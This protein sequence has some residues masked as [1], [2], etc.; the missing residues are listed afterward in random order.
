MKFRPL[1]KFNSDW[2]S[3][4][5]EAR[6]LFKGKVGAFSAACDAFAADP[7]RYRWP[8]DLRVKKHRDRPGVWEMTWSFSSPDGRATFEFET[9]DG[10]MRVVWRRI[11]SHDIYSS[12]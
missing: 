9:V 7:A 8:K 4:K 12:P 2:D 1:P 3:L 11:G 10:E 6:A 5:V